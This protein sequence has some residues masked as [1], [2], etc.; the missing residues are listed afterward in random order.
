MVR[1]IGHRCLQVIAEDTKREDGN[2]QTVAS[3]VRV[4]ASQLGKDLLTVLYY[5]KF[6][7]VLGPFSRT[8]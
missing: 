5:E 2:S 4:S 1:D 7:G 3:K 8:I 6:G